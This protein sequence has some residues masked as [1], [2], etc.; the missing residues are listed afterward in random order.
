MRHWSG[1]LSKFPSVIPAGTELVIILTDFISH[2]QYDAVLA[3]AKRA[4]ISTVRT[5][6]KWSFMAKDIDRVL[7]RM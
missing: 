1:E 3:A 5:Q 2:A 7:S 4:E 6:R